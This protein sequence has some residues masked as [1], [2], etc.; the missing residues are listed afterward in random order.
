MYRRLFTSESITS[1]HPDK[2][3][4]Q[5][6]DSILDE[7]LR[8]DSN[9]RVA[10]EVSI[11]SS[12][13]VIMGEIT[14]KAKLDIPEIAKGVISRI[15]YHT[16]EDGFDLENCNIIVS[17][18]RQSLD[19]A[20]GVDKQNAGAGDQGMMFG[21]AT[22]ETNEYMPAALVYSHKMAKLIEELRKTGE[23]KY[24]RPDGKTQ[25]TIEYGLDG[26]VKRIDTVVISVQHNPDVSLEQIKKDMKSLVI[27]KI[28][29]S[30]YLD[31]KT[32]YYINPT[33]RFVIG[34][35]VG[36][37]G[38]TGRKIIADT[39]GGAGH[40][41]GGA[42]SGKDC[43]KVDRSG[44]YA[45]R[46]VAK[47]IVASGLARK[48]EIQLSYAIGVEYPVSVSV[49]TF[50]T[51]KLSDAELEQIVETEFDLSPKGIREALE[52]HKPIFLQTATYGHFGRSDLDL[53]WER[54]DR[55]EVLTKYLKGVKS[56]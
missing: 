14:T 24:L 46:H 17:V 3:C 45:A 36:D 42:F 19:I 18:K 16:L 55:A 22:D 1:G 56:A 40:H 10:C 29:P 7:C 25:V 31:K 20:L 39:Y 52:L 27:E 44:A 50:G 13:V 48:C 47:N 15:G 54:L 53:P 43:T 26:S 11:N 35:P 21:F 2:V 38:L 5:I 28:I 30:Q 34:G 33:G 8:Q 41:G 51:G 4:D 6:S 49:D 23:L 9:S 32:K 12:L 37:S